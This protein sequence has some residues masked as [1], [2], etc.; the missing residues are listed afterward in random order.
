[1]KSYDLVSCLFVHVGRQR[2]RHVFTKIRVWK[3]CNTLQ[4]V[5]ASVESHQMFTGKFTRFWITKFNPK[6][7]PKFHRKTDHFH[8]KTG[9]KHKNTF[10]WVNFGCVKH[11]FVFFCESV[12]NSPGFR[13]ILE[14]HQVLDIHQGFLQALTSLWLNSPG[15]HLKFSPGVQIFHQATKLWRWIRSW[16]RI[17]SSF[18]CSDGRYVMYV[19]GL[20]NELTSWTGKST[21]FLLMVKST[22]STGPWLQQL[23]MLISLPEATSH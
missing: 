20:V 10:L 1:M 7:I 16:I 17:A 21:H 11:V 22:I 12:V 4:N 23:L 13:Q 14:I 5:S 8:K 15:F 3:V 19:A 6:K 18:H 2:L 9:K